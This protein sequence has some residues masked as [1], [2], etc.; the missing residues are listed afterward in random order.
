MYTK[1]NSSRIWTAFLIMTLLGLSACGVS[2]DLGESDA[3]PPEHTLWTTLLQ[4]HVS[5][6]GRVDYKGFKADSIRLYTYLNTLSTHAPADSW[7]RAERLVYWINAY[8][9][10][11][12]QLIVENYPLQSIQDLH[13]KLYVPMVNSVWHR[14]FFKINGQPMTLNAIEH[15]ILRKEFNEPRIH[16]AIVCASESCPQL[17][18]HAYVADRI[19]EQLTVQA[20]AFINDPKRNKISEDTLELSSIFSWFKGDFTR[21]G[22]LKEY[23]GK[24]TDITIQSSAKISYLDYDWS[25]NE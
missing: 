1:D 20:R 23:I 24:Y 19:D 6:N 4:T 14:K 11:T 10:F 8:N 5:E 7:S 13:P 18:N 12:V 3:L 2:T 9:A 22:S 25:L 21:N 15:K 16:F 17:L